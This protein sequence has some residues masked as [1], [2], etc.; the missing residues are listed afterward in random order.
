MDSDGKVLMNGDAHAHAH[1]HQQQLQ[2]QQLQ[3]V[4]WYTKVRTAFKNVQES[5][6]LNDK[7]D[8]RDVYF[9]NAEVCVC[10]CV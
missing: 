2:Q 10:V 8:I 3:Q 5:A 6:H 7:L 9:I 4:P 1:H